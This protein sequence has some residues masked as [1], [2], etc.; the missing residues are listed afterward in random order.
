MHLVVYTID[1]FIYWILLFFFNLFTSP[2]VN[3]HMKLHIM[4][5]IPS[6]VWKYTMHVDKSIKRDKSQQRFWTQFGCKP[7]A[8]I[9]CSNGYHKR[10]KQFRF[11]LPSVGNSKHIRSIRLFY[12]RIGLLNRSLSVK[13]RPPHVCKCLLLR[14]E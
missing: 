5:L 9:Y 10:G 13:L 2:P 3:C 4:C 12:K 11:V 8:A 6:T 1:I 7:H 14:D